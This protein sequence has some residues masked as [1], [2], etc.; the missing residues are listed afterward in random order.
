MCR[1]DT[2]PWGI[3]SGPRAMHHAPAHRSMCAREETTSCIVLVQPPMGWAVDPN[4][5]RQRRSRSSDRVSTRHT[6]SGGKSAC[7]SNKRWTVLAYAYVYSR[8]KALGDVRSC[9][10]SCVRPVVLTVCRH[11][12][13][14][15]TRHS[16]QPTQMHSRAAALGIRAH[17]TSTATGV[18]RR[19]RSRGGYMQRLSASMIGRVSNRHTTDRR[20]QAKSFSTSAGR[21]TT[22]TKHSLNAVCRLDTRSG[23]TVPTPGYAGPHSQPRRIDCN[24]TPRAAQSPPYAFAFPP[25][26]P[27]PACRLDTRSSPHIALVYRATVC[28]LDTRIGS[29]VPAPGYAGPHNQSSTHSPQREPSRRPQHSHMPPPSRR[30]SLARV[31]TRHTISRPH[32]ALAYRATVCQL[33][34]Q[35]KPQKEKARRSGLPSTPTT[36]RHNQPGFTLN[37]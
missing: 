6:A 26:I 30:D 34:T 15:S 25:R 9:S 18:P 1:L 13:R 3:K 32:T 12:P 36:S 28:R 23:S 29:T 35:P 17:L 8:K 11:G 22:Q 33:D 24:W 19:Q 7:G 2:Q 21:G 31:S 37:S 10:L 5:L 27:L 4:L 14:V 20:T 16:A